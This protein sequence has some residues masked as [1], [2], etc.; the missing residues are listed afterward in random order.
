MAA[1]PRSKHRISAGVF[2][3]VGE[4]GEA[5]EGTIIVDGFG[6]PE[7]NTTL[8]RPYYGWWLCQKMKKPVAVIARPSTMLN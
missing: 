6:E 1:W 7:L 3:G 5:F 2:E 4:N 8:R